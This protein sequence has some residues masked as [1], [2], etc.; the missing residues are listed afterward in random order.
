M[1]LNYLFII[2]NNVI[3]KV[4]VIIKIKIKI[5]KKNKK[6][7]RSIAH[8][9]ILALNFDRRKKNLIN[10]CRSEIIYHNFIDE[11]VYSIFMIKASKK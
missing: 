8:T 2:F 6:R 4:I 1:K 11:E 9:D 7:M 5:E 10:L 3:L